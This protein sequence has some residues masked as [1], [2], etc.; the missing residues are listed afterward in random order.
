[1]NLF[2]YLCFGLTPS[3]IWLLF[4][5][6]KDIHP[7]PKRMVLMIFFY[8][9]IAAVVAALAETIIWEGMFRL[10]LP[11]DLMSF[12]YVFFG[13]ALIEE[14]LKYFAVRKKILS[15][16]EFDEPVDAMLYMII[17]ALGFA[18]LENMLI[19]LSPDMFLLPLGETLT[20]A[21]FRFISATFFHALSSGLVGYFLAL[22]CLENEKRSELVFTGLGIATILHGIYN[23][24][25]I[26]IKG[27]LSFI[28]PIIILIGLALVVSSGFKKLEKTAS[29]CLPDLPSATR[30]R[31]GKIK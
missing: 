24:S 28:I 15:H 12:L 8:G 9:M 31:A 14:I 1:M 20:L 6:R 30:R 26:T 13:I 2:V 27:N 21:S 22:S 23:F 17:S 16:P 10:N 5:L 19:F 7:E 3:I 11:E 18:A 29:V 4:F 25:I